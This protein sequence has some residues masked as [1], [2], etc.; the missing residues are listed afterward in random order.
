MLRLCFP[1]ILLAGVLTAACA[2]SSQNEKAVDVTN[3]D[4][5]TNNP[6]GKNVD[7][8]TQDAM[9]GKITTEDGR[10]LVCKDEI[11]TGSHLPRKICRWETDKDATRLR[12]QNDLMD[13]QRKS[14]IPPGTDRN[15][16]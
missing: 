6:A 3:K 13:I 7:E 11:P 4:V 8:G 14:A 9:T 1:L 10:V 2:T 5:A 12:N 16:R 15:G